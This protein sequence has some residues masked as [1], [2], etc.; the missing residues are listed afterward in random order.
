MCYFNMLVFHDNEFLARLAFT[1]GNRFSSSSYQSRIGFQAIKYLHDLTHPTEHD[2]IH[3]A[4][5][6]HWKQIHLIL[7]SMSLCHWNWSQTQWHVELVQKLAKNGSTLP[8]PYTQYIR[9]CLGQVTWHTTSRFCKLGSKNAQ[10]RNPRLAC[11]FAHHSMGHFGIPAILSLLPYLVQLNSHLWFFQLT[12]K[13][14]TCCAYSI[15]HNSNT[16]SSC[17]GI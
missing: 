10:S 16:H 6:Q 5:Q 13:R 14:F 11:I 1:I 12:T 2:V 17:A 3:E 7:L 15:Q 8:M 4:F 9:G